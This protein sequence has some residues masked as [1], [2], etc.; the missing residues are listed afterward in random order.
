MIPIPIR[1]DSETGNAP[2]K[3][4][5]VLRAICVAAAFGVVFSIYAP[6]ALAQNSP[7]PE[8]LQ[9]ARQL[10]ALV[11]ETTTTELNKRLT[12]EVWQDM[13]AA[14]RSR[15]PNISDAA[16]ADLRRE[17]RAKRQR[18][19]EARPGIEPGLEDHAWLL[20]R[21]SATGP[22]PAIAEAALPEGI[23]SPPA[24]AAVNGGLQRLI[25]NSMSS[26]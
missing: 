19:L 14:L 20:R 8:A 22:P 4:R 11:S 6:P 26:T 3:M 7:S 15:Y 21:H 18:R 24:A 17:C 23:R 16:L 13:V 25:P 5:K 1:R 2:L 12:D 10:V 9:A